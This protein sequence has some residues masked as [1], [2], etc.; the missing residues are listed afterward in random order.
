MN[1]NE[2]DPRTPPK[3]T[4]AER[5]VLGAL[6]LD[7]G[8]L[9]QVLPIVGADDFFH[10]RHRLI[11]EAITSLAEAGT[12][13]D[14]VTLGEWFAG[15][16]HEEAVEGGAYLIELATVTPSSANVVAYARIVREK[17]ALRSM[18]EVTHEAMDEAYLANGDASEVFSRNFA[19]LAALLPKMATEADDPLDLFG[20]CSPPVLLPEY[21]PPLISR[22]AF[23]QAEVMG[24]APEI[25]ALTGIAAAAA[26]T[27]DQFRLQPKPSEPGW[28]ERGCLWVMVVADPGSKKTPAQ[29]KM[30]APVMEL[31][32]EMVR[33]YVGKLNEFEDA[34]RV[35]KLTR[36]EIE[37]RKAKG[38]AGETVGFDEE[39]AMPE[40]PPQRRVM[41]SDSTIEKA[42]D[43]MADNPRGMCFYRDE[44][45]GWFGSMDAYS[46]GAHAKDRPKWLEAYNGGRMVVDRIGRGTTLVENWSMSVVGSIQPDKVRAL[47]HKSD[48][49]GLF[50][51]F[52]VV[53]VPNMY[54][55]ESEREPDR[56]AYKQY[57]NT[58]RE[59]WMREPG[60]GGSGLVTLDI[61]ADALRREFFE[62]VTRVASSEGV[63]TMLRGH[64]AKWTGLWSRLV[65]VYHCFGCA[66]GGLWPAKEP[67][68]KATAERVT[69]MMKR[70]LLPQAMR[71]YGDTAA[72]SDFVYNMAR[73]A[74]SMILAHGKTRLTARDM[75]QSLRAWRDAADWQRTAMVQLM[76]EC[77][78]LIGPDVKRR[79]R[80]SGMESGW[81][82]NPRV[83]VLFAE[84]AGQERVRRSR[85]AQGL[86]ELRM[87]ARGADSGP[88]A[89]DA[90]AGVAH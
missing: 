31:D 32:A 12:P 89:A 70:Y 3:S 9:D 88:T 22:V 47:V 74:A 84:R 13:Y 5:A 18:I 77:G 45:A 90:P 64:L 27:H 52:M 69:L 86:H 67:V 33:D 87:A 82:V 62:W 50:Q 48:D 55:P 71:F 37:K 6:M 78:W 56:A 4:D 10:Y 66:A 79:V 68:R 40:R 58:I 54:R 36:R 20:E 60:A 15:G 16:E 59:L 76:T 39:P 49:D 81:A 51:R 30:L 34:E 57:C 42:A 72:G 8:A 11:F 2:Q 19:R 41:L 44:L 46:K 7:P 25:L 73:S 63:P 29:K 23:D 61:E 24:T 53:E 26:A 83:H 85:V 80:S 28:T 38:A 21:L 17:S 1:I 14:A 35:A 75:Q 43:L 65:L